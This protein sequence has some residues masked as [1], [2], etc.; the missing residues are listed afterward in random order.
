MTEV[1]KVENK[2]IT[3]RTK[4]TIN[5]AVVL[6]PSDLESANL[7]L[8]VPG[9]DLRLHVVPLSTVQAGAD[10][11]RNANILFVQVSPSHDRSCEE[12]ERIVR[13][14]CPGIPVI[15]AVRDLT[16]ADTRRIMRLGVV[17][18]V[19]LPLSGDELHQALDIARGA[20]AKARAGQKR[21]GRLIAFFK[22][23]GGVG[24]TTLAT[25]A[26]CLL[27]S[28]RARAGREVCLI[29]FDVQFGG[30]ALQLD[31]KP[32]L[33]LGDLVAAGGRLDNALLRSVVTQHSSG[34]K[35]IT[36]PE[37]LLPLEALDVDT[38]T[39]II[40]IA[41][42]E[43]DVVL[44]DLPGAWTSWSLSVLAHADAA[45]LVTELSVPSIRQARRQMDL[46]EAQGLEQLPLFVLAN[47]VE[48]GWLKTINLDET[49][50]VLRRKVDFS[51]SNDFRTV[52]AAIDQGKMLG[53][54]KAGSRVQRDLAD[55]TRKLSERL[56]LTVGE[57]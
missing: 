15:A 43:F 14:A 32:N 23:V 44:V 42:R 28:E 2:S 51:I 3:V 5:V 41:T 26:G 50:Q 37:E 7:P 47:R 9:V 33:G 53:E 6:D 40:D 18:V 38:A 22:S 29:D 56:E 39:N 12:L 21:R 45:C 4:G 31:L 25:Q 11:L 30:V 27:A 35:V 36:A 1:C 52:S 17:D 54:I 48:R 57:G 13:V 34:L 8:S 20:I 49:E 46:L 19:P 10:F 24:A 55:V 16:L